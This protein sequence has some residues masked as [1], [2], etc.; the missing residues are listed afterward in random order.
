[1]FLRLQL[2]GCHSVT[3]SDIGMWLLEFHA[4]L[5]C[6]TVPHG[7]RS[8]MPCLDR[9]TPTHSEAFW[10]LC[11]ATKYITV[12]CYLTYSHSTIHFQLCL[13]YVLV[14]GEHKW[15]HV[16][17]LLSVQNNWKRI[18]WCLLENWASLPPP[19]HPLRLNFC[20]KQIFWT[21]FID[22]N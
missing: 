1:M 14:Q 3:I 17:I 20:L 22:E 11:K 5:I 8:R 19:C 18:G 10:L 15:G 12:H 9:D 7:Q 4:S 13:V 6:P 21:V 2:N 16:S